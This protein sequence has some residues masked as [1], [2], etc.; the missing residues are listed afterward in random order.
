MYRALEHFTT[1]KKYLEEKGEE[2]ARMYD[3]VAELH[4]YLGDRDKACI[5]YQSS[6]NLRM[7]KKK[8]VKCLEQAKTKK[9]NEID[10]LKKTSGSEEVSL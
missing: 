8:V 7:N 5:A 1:N 9:K 10:E 2:V 6:L 4:T 3:F